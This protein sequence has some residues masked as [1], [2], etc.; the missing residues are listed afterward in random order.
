MQLVLEVI[1]IKSKEEDLVETHKIMDHCGVYK[2]GYYTDTNGEYYYLKE[3]SRKVY[4]DKIVEPVKDP[5]DEPSGSSYS[6]LST[7]LKSYLDEMVGKILADNHIIEERIMAHID[8]VAKESE[9]SR[10]K[11]NNELKAKLKAEMQYF[12]ARVNAQVDSVRVVIDFLCR[13]NFILNIGSPDVN[14]KLNVSATAP[15]SDD[16]D[17]I[18]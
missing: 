17:A 9:E 13:S 14:P 1:G 3:S 11:L 4:D 7:D 5:S 8:S 12:E 16:V 10:M 2:M 6:F 15:P 18:P